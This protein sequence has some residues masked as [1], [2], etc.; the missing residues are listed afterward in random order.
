MKT[1]TV[2]LVVVAMACTTAAPPRASVVTHPSTF[3]VSTGNS[4]RYY[5]PRAEKGDTLQFECTT[6]HDVSVE[7]LSPTDKRIGGWNRVSSLNSEFVAES[8]GV[9]VVI[10]STSGLAKVTCVGREPR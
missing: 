2:L 3:E 7:L 1:L 8:D 4:Y 9:H 10:V 6:E 5:L